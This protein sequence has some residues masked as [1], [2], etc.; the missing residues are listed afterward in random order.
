MSMKFSPNTAW[1]PK[2]LE[3]VS[4]CPACSS[5]D[6][7]L[8]FSELVDNA[9]FV[10]NGKWNLFQCQNCNSAYLDPRPDK[11][12]IHRAYG[13]YYTHTT[14][15]KNKTDPDHFTG[16]RKWRRMLA[17]GYY[18]Y[19]YGTSRAPESIHGAWLLLLYPKFSRSVRAQFRFLNK[20]QPGQLLL[21]VGCGNGDFLVLAAEVG[22][23]AKGV[24][25]DPKAL[26]VARSRG[27]K[28]IQGSLDEIKKTGELYDVIT[29]S[30]V[31]EHVH[32]PAAFVR[33]AFESLKSGG[34]LYIDTPNVQSL[35]LRRFQKN[36]RGLESPRHLVLFSEQGLRKILKISGFKKLYFVSRSEVRFNIALKSYRIK[37][38]KSPYDE[39]IKK[40]PVREMI[41]TYLPRSFQREEFLTVLARKS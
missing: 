31:I 1:P 2:E 8:L 11:E 25:P 41:K 17:N 19:H 36:W 6:R 3:S 7:K 14:N 30:H 27:V 16:I 21:D 40:L 39:S 35:G 12:S 38:G 29:M 20:P 34:V 37:L 4:S 18:N 26:D 24:E 23:D 28:V 22:W 13:A 9:F 33:L 15:V 5:G 10:A 32:D